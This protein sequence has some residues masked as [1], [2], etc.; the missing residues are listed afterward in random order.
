MNFKQ[1]HEKIAE[2]IDVLYKLGF[3]DFY[4][5]ESGRGRR[6]I[7]INSSKGIEVVI[8][9]INSPD[10]ITIEYRKIEIRPSWTFVNTVKLKDLPSEIQYIETVVNTILS[11]NEERLLIKQKML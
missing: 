6:F 3:V 5:Q 4:F 11:A 10:V 1:S 7:Y 9:D 8:E 2:N